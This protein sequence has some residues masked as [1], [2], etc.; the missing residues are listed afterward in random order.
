MKT[1]T[2]S[3]AKLVQPEVFADTGRLKESSKRPR[4][5]QPRKID[6]WLI[7]RTQDSEVLDVV[8]DD[9]LARGAIINGTYSGNDKAWP[10]HVV[11]RTVE[12]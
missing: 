2:K 9:D 12:V 3:K 4:P 1:A 8:H 10:A 11:K 7:I 5:E 6:I